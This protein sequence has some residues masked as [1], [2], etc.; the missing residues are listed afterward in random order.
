MMGMC[1]AAAGRLIRLRVKQR[2]G[3][4]IRLRDVEGGDEPRF[5]L[6]AGLLNA[7]LVGRSGVP[8]QA[9]GL[10][11]AVLGAR[12]IALPKQARPHALDSCLAWPVTPCASAGDCVVVLRQ[13]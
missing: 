4:L 2:L 11:R 10:M 1:K 13:L 8:A 5:T 12:G 6:L 9:L 3:C 7:R